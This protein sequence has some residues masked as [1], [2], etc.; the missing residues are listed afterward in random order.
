MA[1]YRIKYSIK[2]RARLRRGVIS[3]LYVVY[4]RSLRMVYKM[5]IDIERDIVIREFT[6]EDKDMVTAFFDQMIGESKAFFNRNNG[7]RTN[8]MKF[9]SGEAKN[10]IYFMAEHMKEM[11]GYLFLWDIDTQIPWLGIAVCEKMK[12]MRLG[13]RLMRYAESYARKNGKGGI[14]L[15]THVANLR[16]QSLYESAGYRRMGIHTSGEILY[17]LR[18]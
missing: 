6:L 16:G 8:A 5:A 17:L 10:T 12:G 1:E 3:C 18:L 15:T 2:E 4:V 9:F 11:V 13:G 14:L 7:N